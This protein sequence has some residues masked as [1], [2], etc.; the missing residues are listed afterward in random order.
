MIPLSVYALYFFPKPYHS[1]HYDSMFVGE[2]GGGLSFIGNHKSMSSNA[3]GQLHIVCRVI[4]LGL[5]QTL[6][7][8]WGNINIYIRREI[9]GE[10]MTCMEEE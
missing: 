7:L 9:H 1:H 10:I 8:K 6:T 4:Y 3:I 2:W 5:I